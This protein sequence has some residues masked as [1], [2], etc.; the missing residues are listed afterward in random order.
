MGPFALVLPVASPVLPTR[1]TLPLERGLEVLEPWQ[2]QPSPHTPAG[3]HEDRRNSTHV[4]PGQGTR[5]GTRLGMVASR[6]TP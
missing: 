4:F 5:I 1:N 6:R 2:A 3:G